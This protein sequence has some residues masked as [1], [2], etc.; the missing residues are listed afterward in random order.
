MLRRRYGF[1]NIIVFSI[2]IPNSV[3]LTQGVARKCLNQRLCCLT[4]RQ[5]L[6]NC[7]PWGFSE[8]PHTV[9]YWVLKWGQSGLALPPRPPP[10]QGFFVRQW[11][12]KFFG[13]K[14][15]QNQTKLCG[16]WHVLHG[17]PFKWTVNILHAR[18]NVWSRHSHFSEYRAISSTADWHR[19]GF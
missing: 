17:D 12:F 19:D 10:P 1:P 5:S 15:N 13:C 14:L 7:F 6:V 3:R 8:H 18:K 11:L 16:L 9:S 4:S 2:T